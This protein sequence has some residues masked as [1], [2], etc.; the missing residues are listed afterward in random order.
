M[1]IKKE[2]KFLEKLKNI[3]SP[4]S[5]DKKKLFRRKALLLGLCL[6][7]GACLLGLFLNG[8]KDPIKTVET[9]KSL[10]VIETS[11]HVSTEELWRQTF[12]DG[13]SKDKKELHNEISSVK[14]SLESFKKE[15]ESK[16]EKESIDSLQARL[17]A[18]E[19]EL[20]N[21]RSQTETSV[22]ALNEKKVLHKPLETYAVSL[23][24]SKNAK[25]YTPL[26]TKNNYIPPGAFA[27]AILVS[28]LDAITSLNAST[29]PDPVLLRIVSHGTLPRQFKS[30]LKDCHVIGAAF[31]ELSSERAK[32]RLEKLSCTEKRTGEIIETQV[33][34]F[35]TGE[36]GRQG[37]RG[38]VVSTEGKLI[39]N[40]FLAGM[41][42]G[43]SNTVNPQTGFTMPFVG[44]GKP[45]T[46]ALKE[47]FAG[48]LAG[49]TAASL[50]RLSKYYIDRAEALQ[51]VIQVGA[52]RKVDIIF[53]E[54]AFFGNT[55][56]KKALSK[57]HDERIKRESASLIQ[58]LR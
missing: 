36:D 21:L 27:K 12:K 54:G 1:K 35:V 47:K 23:E 57:K 17:D 28:G 24:N 19:A 29:D 8:Q 42:G 55:E 41:L 33:A 48:N 25:D 32:V 20:Q 11:S 22:K 26:K 51:P 5:F 30:D 3:F 4:K 39:G 52:G 45:E 2:F 10:P 38:S 37:L 18:M 44:T 15:S 13:V 16:N 6:L 31:G 34:G 14:D 46:P 40:A 43:L 58:S 49:G 9:K 53:T 56:L 7:L 50:D